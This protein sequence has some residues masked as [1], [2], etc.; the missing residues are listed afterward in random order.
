MLSASLNAHL[1]PEEELSRF[2]K[3]FQACVVLS[4]QLHQSDTEVRR[5]VATVCLQELFG[6]T[7]GPEHDPYIYCMYLR[8]TLYNV[9]LRGR[10][11]HEECRQFVKKLTKIHVY[12]TTDY[13]NTRK[14]TRQY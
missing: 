2:A 9:S 8:I 3:K 10:K 11:I 4:M 12:F 13:L 1:R 5:R 7:F 6:F 14:I